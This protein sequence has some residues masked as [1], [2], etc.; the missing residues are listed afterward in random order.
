[1]GSL[2]RDKNAT[3][4]VSSF[5]LNQGVGPPGQVT[6]ADNLTGVGQ[7]NVSQFMGQVADLPS[8]AVRIIVDDDAFTL[9]NGEQHGREP[10]RMRK[11]RLG[12]R[13]QALRNSLKGTI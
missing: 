11:Q 13:G 3:T 4:Q 5:R 6:H 10:P 2:I 8:R 9:P 12:F 7:E 1:M